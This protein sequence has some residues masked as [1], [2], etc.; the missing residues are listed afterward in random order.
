MA[1]GY[2]SRMLRAGVSRH[3]VTPPPAPTRADLE[4]SLYRQIWQSASR[5]ACTEFLILALDDAHAHDAGT[6]RIERMFGAG[7]LG[8]MR[9]A[10]SR[11]LEPGP[12]AWD[13]L[14]PLLEAD[15]QVERDARRQAWDHRVATARVSA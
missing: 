1:Q 2:T 7:G 3:T 10:E 9:L 13:T 4:A 14:R 5:N 8:E 11:C 6:L 15:S 12:L